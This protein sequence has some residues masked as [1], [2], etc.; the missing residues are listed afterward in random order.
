MTARRSLSLVLP[1]L[2]ALALAAC[3]TGK[4]KRVFPPTASVQQ[5]VAQDD[6]RWL[7]SLRVQNFSNVGMRVDSVDANLE[8]EGADAGRL[9]L[10]PGIVVPAGSVEVV[11][12][13][14]APSAAAAAALARV[15]ELRGVLDYRLAGTIASSEPDRRRDDFDFESSLARVPGLA[16][17]LR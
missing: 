6:G 9:A 15:L 12:A 1:A 5:L 11:E 2:L 13:S 16:D 10:R 3:S 17:T 4:P 14:L 7:L 8:V